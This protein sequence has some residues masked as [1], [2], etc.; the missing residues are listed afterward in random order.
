MKRATK[1]FGLSVAGLAAVLVVRT[2]SWASVQLQVPP[3]P[4]VEVD[5]AA[6]A[7][8]LARAVQVPT[9]SEPSV[10]DP[11]TFAALHALW[12][13]QYPLSFSRL[14][15]EELGGSLL[16]TWRGSDP[17]LPPVLLLGHQDVVPVEPGSEAA[18]THPPFAGAIADGY[19]WGRGAMDDK[20]A[21]VAILEA[22]ELLLQSGHAPR[23][24]VLLAFGH[25]EEVGGSG[26][27]A[28]ARRLE[29]RGLKP[30]FALD[31]G[32]AMT[33]GLVP[34]VQRDVAL[35]GVAEKGYLTL[36]LTAKTEGGHSSMPPEQSAIGRLSE[37]V[38]RLERTPTSSSL[39]GPTGQ[40]L[41]AV[42]PEMA[43]GLRLVMAN[44]WLLSGLVLRIYESKP[45]TRALVRTTVAPTMLQAGVKENV[46]AREAK[47]TVNFRVRPGETRD[48]VVAWVKRTIA[49]E[50]IAVSESKSGIYSNPSPVTKV[51]SPGYRRVER[52]LKGVFPEVVVA[53]ALVLGATDGRHYAGLTE[54]IIRFGPLLLQQQ[55]L[56]RVHGVNERVSVQGLGEMVRFYRQLLL[57]SDA[58]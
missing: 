35:L 42:G 55:D 56:G 45:P 24:T 10:A 11:E 43:F 31:E 46:L 22:V 7:G 17:A 57:E 38:A 32:L 14:E 20:A 40:F 21:V 36:E 5:A 15:V 16:F 8:R 23:R 9:V 33:R 6:A 19:V 37:A 49:D 50:E 53:P 30:L 26:A 13:E 58:D 48:D 4:K 27:V 52:A 44:R 41:D 28:M 39:E 2:L 25:D 12:R 47:A 3:A 51:D 18:W 29:E 34:G 54:S 1:L